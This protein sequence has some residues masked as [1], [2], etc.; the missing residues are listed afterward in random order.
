MDERFVDDPRRAL[1]VFRLDE[2]FKILPWV[3]QSGGVVWIAE[4]DDRAAGVG[5]FF[6]Q[7]RDARGNGVEVGFWLVGGCQIEICGVC[8]SEVIGEGRTGDDG[9]AVWEQACGEVDAFDG[10]CGG[11]ELLL[12]VVGGSGEE[13]QEIVGTGGGI[14]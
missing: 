10:A 4:Q 8:S 9:W 3:E 13:R 6:P 2:T 7:H 14:A 12:G 1:S 5:R 11:N